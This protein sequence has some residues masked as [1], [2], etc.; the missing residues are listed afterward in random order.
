MLKGSEA[1]S[2]EES[3]DAF[4][5]IE[6]A[7]QAALDKSL[8]PR[9]TGMLFDVV[10]GLGL[11]AGANVIDVGC[12]EGNHAIELAA[13]F[14]FDVL[15]VDPLPRHLQLAR[16]AAAATGNPA[17]PRFELGFADS[18]PVPDGEVNLIWCREVLCH[19]PDL[20]KA[21]TEFRRVLRDEGRAVVEAT[22]GAEDIDLSNVEWPWRVRADSARLARQAIEGAGM[23]IDEYIDVGSEWGEFSQENRNEAGRRLLHIARL[24]RSPEHYIDEFGEAN[25]K[26][27]LG[28]C[29]WHVYRM[30][31]VLRTGVFV[32]SKR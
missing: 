30:T 28:D 6:E 24:L 3:Y 23:H 26:I 8:H 31:G 1:R 18:I 11:P 14:K 15:G 10:A 17:S 5:R 22:F 19:V 9:S 7:F 16:E 27:M 29:F 13:R 20:D 2:N 21:F 32:L 4:P 25:Y 12:G